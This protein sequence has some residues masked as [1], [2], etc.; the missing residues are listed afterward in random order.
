MVKI[1]ITIETINIVE[2]AK[3]AKTL[4]I[5]DTIILVNIVNGAKTIITKRQAKTAKTI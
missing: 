4:I 3:E 1:V 2:I 5:V